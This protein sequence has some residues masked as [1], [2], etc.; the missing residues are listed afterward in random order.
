MRLTP[1]QSSSDGVVKATETTEPQD[2]QHKKLFEAFVGAA[3]IRKVRN[4]MK[5]IA[6]AAMP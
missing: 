1:P 6:L 4:L 2:E 5:C 3:A